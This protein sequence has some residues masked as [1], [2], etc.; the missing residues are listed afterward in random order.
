MLSHLYSNRHEEEILA[1]RFKRMVRVV[2]MLLNSEG[3]YRQ[4]HSKNMQYFSALSWEEQKIV[5]ERTKLYHDLCIE[6]VEDRLSLRDSRSFVWKALRKLRL[7]CGESVLDGITDEHVVEIHSM[8]GNQIFRNY[9]FFQFCSYSIEEL[10]IK[11]M[12]SLENRGIS[13]WCE[14]H[15]PK[16]VISETDSLDNLRVE[17]RTESI[18]PLYSKNEVVALL[19]IGKCNLVKE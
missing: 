1:D 11:N 9:Q 16:Y 2:A 7:T 8:D 12:W 18:S 5:C 6:Q 3:L 4:A 15:I 13:N 19:V 17:C 14:S 10:C